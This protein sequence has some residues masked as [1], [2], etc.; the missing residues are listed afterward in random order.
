MGEPPSFRRNLALLSIGQASVWATVF[1]SVF[2]GPF[3]VRAMTGSF[4]FAGLPVAMYSL[5]SL[6]FVVP[7][8]RWMDRV[9]R[10]P[11]LAFGHAVAAI[12]ACGV[13]GA[14][15]LGSGE[16]LGVPL[17]LIGLFLLTAGSA[18]AFLTRVAVADLYTVERRAQGLGRFIVLS[19][20][21]SAVGAAAFL[22]LGRG[23]MPSLASGYLVMLPLFA[24][25]AVS[26]ILLRGT[27]PAPATRST[28]S[29]TRMRTVIGRPGVRWA[30][31]SNAGANAGM[32][33][34]MS[35]ASPALAAL[36]G[37][38]MAGVMLAHFGG[39]FLPAPVAGR[40]GDRRGRA[41]SI[42]MGGL[43]LAIGAVLFTRTDLEFVAGLGLF[44]VGA[45]WCMTFIP[46]TALLADSAPFDERGTLFGA[47]DATV[48]IVGSISVVAAG[49]AFSSLGV[50]GLAVLGSALA[51]LPFIAGVALR[52]AP[53]S[54]AVAP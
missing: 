45:G 50:V 44:L 37:P 47:N 49:V 32:S 23:D 35:L 15:I 33:G 8:G 11:V 25:G 21:G 1:F 36:S 52:R 14:L 16:A 54:P 13:A 30:I 29:A 22:S 4:A 2:L 10:A 46:G 48:A 24:T 9:G 43:V 38:A 27:L 40:L 6:L 18:I 12:G 31:G 42:L 17:F 51:A 34:V 39:M 53:G 26:M 5:S 3:A 20:I 41:L 19:F 7:A 28:A